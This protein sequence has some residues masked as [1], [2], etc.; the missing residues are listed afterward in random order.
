MSASVPVVIWRPLYNLNSR[1][2]SFAVCVCHR[3]L[4]CLR[5]LMQGVARCMHGAS[6][7]SPGHSGTDSSTQSEMEL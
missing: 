5:K 1:V 7:E 4:R 3:S 6:G 2:Y